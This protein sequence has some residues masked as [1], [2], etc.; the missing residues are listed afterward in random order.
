MSG[1]DQ[2]FEGFSHGE[3][4]QELDHFADA[5]DDVSSSGGSVAEEVDG[6]GGERV[7]ENGDAEDGDHGSSG[8]GGSDDLGDDDADWHGNEGGEE[9]HED[10]VLSAEEE[11]LPV[12]VGLDHED[13]EDQV[14]H[15]GGLVESGGDGVPHEVVIGEED[16]EEPVGDPSGLDGLL[17]LLLEVLLDHWE[18]VDS[19]TLKGGLPEARSTGR[20]RGK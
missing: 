5:V 1:V 16:L 3:G 2:L 6:S 12:W 7:E 17:S 20:R 15:P 14:E 4:H 10:D 9:D 19:L 13:H 8:V 11:A 18:L